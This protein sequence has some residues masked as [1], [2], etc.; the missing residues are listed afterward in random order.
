M[1]TTQHTKGPLERKRTSR[2]PIT[3]NGI[4]FCSYRV[5]INLYAMQDANADRDVRSNRY[6]STYSAYAF[7]KC[8]GRMFRHERT[9]LEAAAKAR[10]EG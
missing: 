6:S 7:G 9:A 8:L 4:E 3:V 10:G 2:A 5:G 1:S